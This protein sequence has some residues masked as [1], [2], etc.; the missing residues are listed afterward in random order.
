MNVDVRSIWVR[1][2]RRRATVNNT[3]DPAPRSLILA[4]T[5][6]FVLTV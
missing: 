1:H 4:E 6:Y 5:K 3:I 2:G